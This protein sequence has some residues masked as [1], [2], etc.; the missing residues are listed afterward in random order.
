MFDVDPAPLSP[1]FY[2][3]QSPVLG[4]NPHFVRAMVSASAHCSIHASEDIVDANGLKLWTRGR[5]I[6][7]RLL[8]RLSNRKLRKPIELCVYAADPIA[9]AG[10]AETIE[11]KVSASMDLR[12]ALEQDLARVLKTVRGISPNPTELML[13]SVMRYAEREMMGHAALVSA[14]ALASAALVDVHPDVLR[15]LARAALLHDVGE[16]YLAP[17][18]FE[19]RKPRSADEIRQIR[20]HPAIGAQ[21][22]IELARSGS[23]VGHLIA[24]SHERLDGWG[25][26][27][28]LTVDALPLPAQALLFAEAISPMLESPVNGLQRAAVAVRLVPGEFASAMVNWIVRWGHARPIEPQ[29]DISAEAIGLDL[30]QTYCVLVRVRSLLHARAARETA[31]VRAAASGWLTAVEALLHEL[32][33]TGVEGAL[34]GGLSIEPQDDTEMIELSVLSR[35]LLYRIRTLLLRV[36]I[37]RADEPELGASSLVVELLEALRACQPVPDPPAAD[38][39]AKPEM[40]PWSDLYCVG[41]EEIDQQ[42]RVLVGLLNRLGALGGK[43]ADPGPVGEILANLV[44]YV[45]EHFANE[46]R[47]MRE[48]GYPDAEA[49]IAAHARLAERV[50]TM[51]ARH[52]QG[53]TPALDELTRFLRQ[54]L[55][56]HILQTDKA[57]GMALNA[58][59]VQ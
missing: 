12:A 37:A 15:T 30:H 25:Y 6:D 27:R 52:H 9:A 32:R 34:S 58:T 29:P 14:V 51:V 5:A 13:L 41:V 1:L 23:T 31:A 19:S 18:L 50:E 33:A 43:G 28:G 38:G 42:H 54:W 3:G 36:E 47:L 53:M 21:V 7:D 24:L 48:H 57:L 4:T 45:H 8:E 17:S 20:T 40:L 26:P 44:A 2:T 35:E 55:I 22:A 46:E 39:V 16:L 10:L 56:S 59:G 49:H 11:G